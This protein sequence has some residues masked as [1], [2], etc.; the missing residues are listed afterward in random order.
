MN[1]TLTVI[2]QSNHGLV[3]EISENKVNTIAKIDI[4]YNS[5]SK[6]VD[7]K[8][9]ATLDKENKQLLFH[10]IDGSFIKS[11]DVPFGIAMNVKDSVVYVGGN[12]RDGEVCYMVDLESET[13][14]LQNIELPVPMGWGKA[15]DDILIV[16]N[17]MML[18]DDIVYPKYTFE[19]DISTPNKPVWVKTIELPHRRTYEDI[20]KGDMNEDWMIYLSSSSGIDHNGIY[21]TIEGKKEFTLKAEQ[22]YRKPKL[23]FT[24][25]DIALVGDRLYVLTD[26]G[27]G[28]YDLMVPSIESDDIRFV[29]HRIA[30]MRIIKVDET[31]L[32]L[33]NKYGYE[34]ID[35]ENLHRFNGTTMDRFWSYGSIDLSKR[36]LEE[37]PTE[38]KH[39]EELQY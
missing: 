9:I 27:L 7:N 14:S 10:A 19:Y 31:R 2:P 23:N 25:K 20:I 16:G 15:V 21:I 38:I 12:A 24:Y 28:Y 4:P 35:L 6:I 36:E 30:A 8:T 39:L 5:I 13:Q 22:R 26:I 34:L 3:A 11:M 32:M 1:K 29:E 33:I 37:F 18:I 17:K